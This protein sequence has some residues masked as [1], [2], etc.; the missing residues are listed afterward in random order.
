MIVG[1][2]KTSLQSVGQMVRKGKRDLSGRWGGEA[3]VHRQNFFFIGE[4]TALLLRAFR[5]TKS[6]LPGLSRIVSL[7]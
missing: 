6:G 2:G 5:W 3:A 7:A 1:A 4:A